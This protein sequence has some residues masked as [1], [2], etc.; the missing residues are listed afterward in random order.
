M[1]RTISCRTAPLFATT[2]RM[3]S[4]FLT[5]MAL[6][7]EAHLVAHADADGA[8]DLL[9]VALLPEGG[10]FDLAGVE[11]LRRR[12][13]LVACGRRRWMQRRRLPATRTLRICLVFIGMLPSVVLSGRRGRKAC[14]RSWSCCRARALQPHSGRGWA[15]RAG[16][17]TRRRRCLAGACTNPGPCS[18]RASR[19]RAP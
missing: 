10:V 6:R 9:R 7:V 2:N 13:R 3:V 1:P 15:G 8:S 11:L 19:R 16:R 18:R 5:V 4:P 17:C 12:V 14:E